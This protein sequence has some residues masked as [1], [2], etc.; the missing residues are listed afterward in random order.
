MRVGMARVR[1]S[2]ACCCLWSL[3]SGIRPRFENLNA[4]ALRLP[5]LM[6]LG[7]PHSGNQ[8]AELNIAP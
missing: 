7:R 5:F 4:A 6:V 1:R 8:T 2:S 3:A